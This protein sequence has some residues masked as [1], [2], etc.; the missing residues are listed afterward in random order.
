[1]TTNDLI[2]GREPGEWTV[3]E[4]KAQ[5]P[6][7]LWQELVDYVRFNTRQSK[8]GD[9]SEVDGV[10]LNKCPYVYLLAPLLDE[11]FLLTGN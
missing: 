3:E 5:L 4:L 8:Q 9:P 2:P 1:M 7:R 10:D 6:P 11:F